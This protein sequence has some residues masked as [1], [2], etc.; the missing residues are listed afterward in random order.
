MS[1]TEWQ[2]FRVYGIPLSSDFPFQN[3]LVA[4]SGP[5]DLKFSH[6]QSLPATCFDRGRFHSFATAAKTAEGDSPLYFYQSRRFDLIRLTEIADF[7]CF[8]RRIFCRAVEGVPNELLEIHFLGTVLAFWLERHGIRALHASAVSFHGDAVA[9][10]SSNHGG[11]SGLAASLMSLGYPLLT[12]DI[13]PVENAPGT[14]L[15]RP[16]YPTM[17]MWPDEVEFFLGGYEHLP[18]VHPDFSKRRIF[19]GPD[20]FGTFCEEPQPLALIYLPERRP[21]GDPDGSVKIIPVSPRDG[22]IELI[23]H[24]FSAHLAEAAGLAAQRLDFF[25]RMAGQVPMRRLVY[26]SGFEH[27][28]RVRDA[29][30]KDARGG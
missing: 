2:H 29:V 28:E 16:G 23:R 13:L 21:A 14:F 8:P 25:A 12:D 19:V 24:S 6:R 27:L 30:L 9:F 22:V 1:N 3:R 26:P 18:L 20:A 10:L 15:G 4:G 17:R 5:S 7:C 11:K